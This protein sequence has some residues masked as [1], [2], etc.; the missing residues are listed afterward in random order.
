[1][2]LIDVG[3]AAVSSLRLTGGNG[4]VTTVFVTKV[5]TDSRLSN[6][7]RSPLLSIKSVVT[8]H[9][10]ATATVYCVPLMMLFSVFRFVLLENV[11]LSLLR[12]SI[13]RLVC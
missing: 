13:V 3:A 10:E 5:L 6:F 1:M 12:L 4:G 9:T 2:T 11:L 8:L 7:I